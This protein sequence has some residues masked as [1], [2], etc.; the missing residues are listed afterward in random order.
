MLQLCALGKEA[1]LKH[2]VLDQIIVFDE[3][4]NGKS[5]S[6]LTA[7]FSGPSTRFELSPRAKQHSLQPK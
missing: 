4:T 5:R 7:V 1:P 2:Y 6:S 3:G